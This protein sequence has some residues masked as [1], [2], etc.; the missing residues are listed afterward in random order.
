VT[1]GLPYMTQQIETNDP[2]AL[3]PMEQRVFSHSAGAPVKEHKHQRQRRGVL[4]VAA[5]TGRVAVLAPLNRE[6]QHKGELRVLRAVKVAQHR[7]GVVPKKGIEKQVRVRRSKN[8]QELREHRLDQNVTKS[9]A[10]K[11]KLKRTLGPYDARQ[12]N[13]MVGRAPE[14]LKFVSV[15][16]KPLL[17]GVKNDEQLHKRYVTKRTQ[18]HT[19][20]NI[21]ALLLARDFPAHPERLKQ[22]SQKEIRKMCIAG[23]GQEIKPMGPEG[24][25]Q[26]R[27]GKTPQEVKKMRQDKQNTKKAQLLFQSSK[28]GDPVN[29][30]KFGVYCTTDR[31]NLCDERGQIIP[32]KANRKQLLTVIR[33]A[34]LRGGIEPNPGPKNKKYRKQRQERQMRDM[35]EMSA[36][37]MKEGTGVTRVL[38]GGITRFGGGGTVVAKFQYVDGMVGPR[39]IHVPYEPEPDHPYFGPVFEG[40]VFVGRVSD[41]EDQIIDEDGN[42]YDADRSLTGFKGATVLFRIAHAQSGDQ[43]AVDI[44][45]KKDEYERW[46]EMY[47]EITQRK[48]GYEVHMLGTPPPASSLPPPLPPPPECA[49]ACS[50]QT[51]ETGQRPCEG[52]QCGLDEE[53]NPFGCMVL[54]SPSSGCEV[55]EPCKTELPRMPA[56]IEP[57]A[58]P[59]ESSQTSGPGA[60]PIESGLTRILAKPVPV[61]KVPV[62]AVPTP[63]PAQ[64]AVCKYCGSRKHTISQCVFNINAATARRT[65][66]GCFKCG[67]PGHKSADCDLRERVRRNTQPEPELRDERPPSP[68]MPARKVKKEK[69][70]IRVQVNTSL[71]GDEECEQLDSDLDLLAGERLAERKPG[72]KGKGKSLD[73]MKPCSTP[74]PRKRRGKQCEEGASSNGE[75]GDSPPREK[76]QDNVN[77]GGEEPQAPPSILK[78]DYLKVDGTRRGCWYYITHLLGKE[79]VDEREEIG[80]TLFGPQYYP[81]ASRIFHLPLDTTEERLVSW[82]G[83]SRTNARLELRG[84][85]YKARFPWQVLA[86]LAVFFMA[87]V[88]FD[89]ILPTVFRGPRAVYLCY[90][91]L[92]IPYPAEI[93]SMAQ[94]VWGCAS[95]VSHYWPA[96]IWSVYAF[97][98]I[99]AYLSA[100]DAVFRPGK[101]LQPRVQKA[102]AWA[103]ILAGLRMIPAVGW[104]VPIVAMPLVILWRGAWMGGPRGF[105][106][107]PHLVT[108]LLAE[109]ARGTNEETL[110]QTVHARALRNATLPI[111][112]RLD[113]TGGGDFYGTT[114]NDVIQASEELVYYLAQKRPFGFCP[115]LIHPLGF[116]DMGEP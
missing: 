40:G 75:G 70:K 103:L 114:A 51:Q 19:N 13:S 80:H 85:T 95:Y 53:E 8:K 61:A 87:Y 24:P 74:P 88:V 108:S 26:P 31:A 54:S 101:T 43:F 82:R 90:S 11:M 63:R 35:G 73:D 102:W 112:D 92:H 48:P 96:L 58:P 97:L 76:G 45:L 105:V 23:S 56:E 10:R 12:Y 78:G 17:R 22:A 67:E 4:A 15:K 79:V 41:H 84:V 89:L 21:K 49:T 109:Y 71:E 27:Q 115:P 46:H 39:E 14:E 7:H 100:S 37:Y 113:L 66:F 18:R 32:V 86:I 110:R 106:Y 16:R 99:W 111:R 3:V 116:V 59:L 44:A 81:T 34:L 36:Y 77:G 38:T 98:G 9:G 6:M 33:A 25:A 28:K 64:G 42:T 68:D 57:S 107:C 5:R 93:V 60:E 52:Q 62:E 1:D 30:T 69:D 47:Q 2:N 20:D 91:E 104:L 72:P 65:K 29:F 83:V 94:L 50:T 55:I